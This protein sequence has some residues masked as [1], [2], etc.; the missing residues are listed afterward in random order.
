MS[1]ASSLAPAYV[2]RE[3]RL[4][5]RAF[6]FSSWQG[7]DR[8]SPIG[9]RLPKTV[10]E[11]ETRRTIESILARRGVM[12]RVACDPEEPDAILGFA[13]LAPAW[14]T[15]VVF[16]VYVR[17]IDGYR[18]RGIARSL[19]ADLLDKRVFY[20][21]EPSVKPRLVDGRRVPLRM[22]EGW[23]FNPHRNYR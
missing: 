3:G 7:S 14:D 6:V 2:L 12:I 23:T 11:S 4:T 5:D 1:A 18:E 10:H 13:V 20:T 15:P 17:D 16:F 19:L 21:H 8:Y 22:P 9:C